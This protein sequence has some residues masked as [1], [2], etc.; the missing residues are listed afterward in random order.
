MKNF[1]VHIFKKHIG[2]AVSILVLIAVAVVVILHY[3]K[4]MQEGPTA[5]NVTIIKVGQIL[6]GDYI[7]SN[8]SEPGGSQG[9]SIY[10]WYRNRYSGG[11][12][13]S[14]GYVVS[15][16]YTTT[17]EAY[18]TLTSADAGAIIKFEVTPVSGSDEQGN[19]VQ[20]NGLAIATLPS[21]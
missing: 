11:V 8:D 13:A 1:M 5:K 21:T 15:E 17:S 9:A 3:T 2:K 16:G 12:I 4:A 19:P 10:K 7:Y 14:E 18:Y 6:R 20:S